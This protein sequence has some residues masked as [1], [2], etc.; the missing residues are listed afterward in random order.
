MYIFSF[1]EK[2]AAINDFSPLCSSICGVLT[3]TS[4]DCQ[5]LWANMIPKEAI[6]LYY[7]RDWGRKM[8]WFWNDK[9]SE[10]CDIGK[11]HFISSWEDCLVDVKKYSNEIP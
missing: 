5:D 8:D 6:D 2:K 11:T 9:E 3:T 1:Y 4:R 7:K 10:G